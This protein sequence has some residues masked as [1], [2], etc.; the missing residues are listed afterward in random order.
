[1]GK[2]GTA[3]GGGVKAASNQE[4]MAMNNVVNSQQRDSAATAAASAATKV[5]NPNNGRPP[6]YNLR[7]TTLFNPDRSTSPI[8]KPGSPSTVSIVQTAPKTTLLNGS[9]K[10]S[11]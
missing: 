5:L 11:A 6:G 2:I 10:T 8:A 1:M 4:R 7:P 9:K 3:V